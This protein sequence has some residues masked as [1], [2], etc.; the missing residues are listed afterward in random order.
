[1]R[2]SSILLMAAFLTPC[3]SLGQ[4]DGRKI[5][6]SHCASCHGDKGQ[7]VEEEHEKPLWGKKSVDALA[8][9]IHKSM[10]E[11]KEDT[12]VNED[13]RAVARYIYDAFYSPAAQARNRPPR[14]E[15]LRMT[16]NQYRQSAA[17]LIES[18]KRPQTIK[19]ERGLQGRYFNVE[20]MN[21]EKEHVLERIDPASDFDW[22]TGV[23]AE[24]INQKGFSIRW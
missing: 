15:L 2:S 17:D 22:G 6:A 13:A 10:P 5:Y 14:I 12:V 4:P 16:N 24:K 7:G 20:K 9:Y 11:D 21:K 1:M 18:F 3:T 19:A 23:P 8:R